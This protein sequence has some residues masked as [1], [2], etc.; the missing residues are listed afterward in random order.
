MQRYACEDAFRFWGA[1]RWLS[2]DHPIHSDVA[3]LEADIWRDEAAVPYGRA[4]PE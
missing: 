4:L 2:P 1:A 3:E